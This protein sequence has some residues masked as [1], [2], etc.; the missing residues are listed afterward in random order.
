MSDFGYV[1]GAEIVGDDDALL[2]ALAVSG[3]GT[4]EIVG[5]VNPAVQA[6][7]ARQTKAVVQKRLESSRRYPLGFTPTA[8]PANGTAVVPAGPQALFRAERIIVPSDIAFDLGITDLKVGNSSQLAQSVE[9]P[10][11]MFT[12]VAIDSRITFDTAEIGNQISIS[13]RNKTGAIVNFSAGMLGTV[14]K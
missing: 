9:V 6:A 14:A 11:A 12:E 13:L 3:Y 4:Q 5:A 1:G 10:A 8:V 7:M 2:Q